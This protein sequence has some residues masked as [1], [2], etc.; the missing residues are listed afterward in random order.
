MSTVDNPFLVANGIPRA[1]SD[2][3][4][5]PPLPISMSLQ[6]RANVHCTLV[7]GEQIC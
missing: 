7:E 3:I 4:V 1:V 5:T 6:P 2:I